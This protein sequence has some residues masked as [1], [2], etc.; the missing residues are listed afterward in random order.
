MSIVWT[1]CVR[2]YELLQEYGPSNIVLWRLRSRRGLRWGALVGLAGVVVYGG[3][4]LGISYAVQQGLSPWLYLL[5]AVALWDAI[6][7]L[8]FIPISA[9]KLFRVRAQEARM[10]RTTIRD[11]YAAEAAEGR[12]HDKLTRTERRELLVGM[13]AQSRS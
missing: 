8:M 4:F 9:V 13:R 6:K 5:A 2:I 1:I 11:V 10:L 3:I 7:F 12:Q